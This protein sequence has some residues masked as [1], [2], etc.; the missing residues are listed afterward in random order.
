[1]CIRE[2]PDCHWQVQGVNFIT[3]LKV[4]AL[5]CYDIIVGMDWLE[6][7]SPMMIHWRKKILSFLYLRKR[8]VLRGLKM[9]TPSCVLMTTRTEQL[10]LEVRVQLCLLE[11]EPS[12]IPDTVHRL[13]SKFIEVFE[14]KQGLPPPHEF[15]HAIRPFH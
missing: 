3:S 11:T 1:M 15:D 6:Q 14:E 4:L 5:G 13:L 9:D 10:P 12:L 2:F 8:V 7:H